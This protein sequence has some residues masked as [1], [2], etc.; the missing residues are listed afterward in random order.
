ML[1]LTTAGAVTKFLRAKEGSLDA[2]LATANLLLLDQLQVY[3]PNKVQFLFDLL[4]DRLND[5]TSRFKSWKLEP[6]VWLLFSHVWNKLPGDSTSK[7][8]VSRKLKLVEALIAVFGQ[9]PSP[10][11]LASIHEVLQVYITNTYLVVDEN[12]AIVLLGT[13]LT[14]VSSMQDSNLTAMAQENAQI[15]TD[16]THSIKI[17]YT[18]SRAQITHKQNKKLVTKFF[19]ECLPPALT[20]QLSAFTVASKLVTGIVNETLFHEETVPLLGQNV[21]QLFAEHADQFSDQTVEVFF[22][23]IIENVSS[24]DIKICEEVFISIT[25]TSKFSHMSETLLRILAS[26]NRT[27]SQEFFLS[28]Y[29]TETKE[30]PSESLNWK[31]VSY[32]IELDP[33]FALQHHEEIWKKLKPAKKEPKLLIGTKLVDAFIKTR[34]FSLFFNTVWP[35]RILEDNFWKSAEYVDVVSERINSFSLTQ[36]KTIISSLVQETTFESSLPILTSLIKGLLSCPQLKINSAKQML[37]SCD[38]LLLGSSPE[39]WEAKFYFLC[40]FG[41]EAV[42]VSVQNSFKTPANSKYFYYSVFRY[43][44]TTGDD[45]LVDYKTNFMSFVKKSKGEE[46]KIILSA[47]LERWIIIISEFFSQEQN[48]SILKSIFK[49]LDWNSYLLPFFKKS[50]GVFFEQDQIVTSLNRYVVSAYAQKDILE[51]ISLIPVSVMDKHTRKTLIEGIANINSTDEQIN[52]LSK[53]ALLH[54]LSQSSVASALETDL[55]K[56]INVYTQDDISREIVEVV[57]NDHLNQINDA[58][59]KAY[60]TSSLKLLNKHVKKEPKSITAQLQI[61]LIILSTMAKRSI[62]DKE[63]NESRTNLL[64]TFIS[65]VNTRL[66]KAKSADVT[67]YLNALCDLLDSTSDFNNQVPLLIS[68]IGKNI[69]KYDEQHVPEIKSALFALLVKVSDT[70]MKSAVFILAL[71]V[72]LGSCQSALNDYIE[73][74]SSSDNDIFEAAYRLTIKTIV[75]DVNSE[76]SKVLVQI[77]VLFIRHS[78]KICSN[79]H[80]QLFSQSLSLLITKYQ[81]GSIT[82]SA[83]IQ[84]VLATLKDNLSDSVWLYSQYGIELTLTYLNLVV[85]D[86]NSSDNSEY[87]FILSSQVF[88]HILL[89]HRFRLN[90]RHHIVIALFTTMLEQLALNHN[91]RRNLLSHSVPAATAFSRLLSNLCEPP[92]SSGPKQIESSLSSASALIKKSLRAHLHV[93]LSNYIFTQLN[94]N[95]DSKVN[96]ELLN[97]IYKVFDVL[98]KRELQLVNLTIDNSGKAYYKTLYANYKDYGKWK[99]E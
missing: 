99:D 39:L 45:S 84:L 72:C 48:L 65:L 69:S 82:D 52:I 24:K 30:S 57:W 5:N 88:S 70:S 26:A 61:G 87:L 12:S 91:T 97:G 6:Q 76:N 3:L 11:L 68:T 16:F 49:H 32:I 71:Y 41:D 94:F 55:E 38:P 25:S 78:K 62:Q 10:E 2:I 37:L 58:P 64:Q 80:S 89:F 67:W 17:I 34:E 13:Y 28:L 83:S 90:S 33:E 35:Q 96:S 85:I 15:V 53:K 59:H 92:T 36:L 74:L 63:I 75:K 22:N 60:I 21:K 44:E 79:S 51:L 19:L 1:D 81:T 20:F 86:I 14:A 46:L 95:F 93:L 40:L 66:Q 73:K 77:L 56:L 9:K 8:V 29:E 98:S 31:L 47:V 43:I 27:L 7:K 42:N 54:L 4:C 18:Y 23:A 50:S